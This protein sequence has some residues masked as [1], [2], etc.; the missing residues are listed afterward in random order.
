MQGF[1]IKLDMNILKFLFNDT[2]FFLSGFSGV[3]CLVVDFDAV[4]NV[5]MGTLGFCGA[6]YSIYNSYLQNKVLKKQLKN[7][8]HSENE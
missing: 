2:N 5:T 7:L 3:V 4:F 8:N 6:C 1:K